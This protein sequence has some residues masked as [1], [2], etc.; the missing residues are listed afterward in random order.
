VR[1]AAFA[2]RPLFF[3]STSL[4]A[5]VTAQREKPRIE[6]ALFALQKNEH[7]PALGAPAQCP[8]FYSATQT[9]T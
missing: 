1:K 8:D 5:D 4:T 7:L 3:R 2:R 6:F 9:V